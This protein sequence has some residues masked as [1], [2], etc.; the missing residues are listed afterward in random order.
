MTMT[1]TNLDKV[2]AYLEKRM[3]P[4]DR[5]VE[6]TGEEIQSATGLKLSQ[7]HDAIWV[8]TR[9]GL[10]KKERPGAR[11][12]PMRIRILKLVP[13]TLDSPE[14]VKTLLSGNVWPCPHCGRPLDLDQLWRE[15]TEY[16]HEALAKL[17][18]TERQRKRSRKK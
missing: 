3:N 15:K 14:Q 4:A 12:R 1:E 9:K 10:L 8:L 7:V 18:Q 16:L 5:T 13:F 6:I 2:L 11:F 17:K